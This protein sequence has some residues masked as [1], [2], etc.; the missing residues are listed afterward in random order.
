[1]KVLVHP[2]EFVYIYEDLGVRSTVVPFMALILIVHSSE[3]I[4]PEWDSQNGMAQIVASTSPEGKVM[5]MYE[6]LNKCYKSV[7]LHILKLE[8]KDRIPISSP[9]F[10]VPTGE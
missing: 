10:I 2:G 5:Y 3:I 9:L 6:Y 4:V 8:N 1:M 7:A